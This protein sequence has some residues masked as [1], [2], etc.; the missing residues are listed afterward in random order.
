[1]TEERAFSMLVL[2]LSARN[3]DVGIKTNTKI[4]AASIAHIIFFATNHLK[5]MQKNLHQNRSKKNVMEAPS[6]VRGTLRP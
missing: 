4:H 2:T 5:R 3:C 1:M 6:P